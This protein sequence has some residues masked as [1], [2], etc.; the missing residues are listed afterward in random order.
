MYT[1]LL[2]LGIIASILLIAVVLMQPG[3]GD[4]L[5]GMGNLTSSFT[6]MFG[7]RQTLDLLQK[8]TI[9]LA[10]AILVFT[11]ITNKFFV[12]QQQTVPKPFIEGTQLPP[13]APPV[14]Q[15]QIPTL[16]GTK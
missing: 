13:S 3:K 8:I 7:S 16:P 10:I 1:V 11:I 2:I 9:G 14:G 12:S 4:M 15:P 6:S 5:T